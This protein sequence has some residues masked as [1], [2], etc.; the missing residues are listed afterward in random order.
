[1]PEVCR[2]GKRMEKEIKKEGERMTEKRQWFIKASNRINIP[3]E[4]K[5]E[6][7]LPAIYV[8]TL[9][10]STGELILTPYG[11]KEGGD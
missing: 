3:K 5:K 9:L 2:P 11:K 6:I 10:K 8:L 4:L 7:E 1:M